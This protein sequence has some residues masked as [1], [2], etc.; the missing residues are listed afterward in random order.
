METQAQELLLVDTHSHLYLED[1]QEDADQ[2]VERSLRGEF[3]DL[4]GRRSTDIEYP[5]R[6]CG[7]IQPGI[8][9]ETSRAAL[10]FCQ[11]SPVLRC[12]VGIHPNYAGKAT[13]EEWSAITELAQNPLVVGIGETGLDLYWDYTPLDCQIDFLKRHVQLARRMSLPIII[14]CRSAEAELMN[15]LRQICSIHEPMSGII[16][17]FSGNV[18]MAEEC[19][20]YGFHISFSGSVTYP[21]KKFAS[22]WEA[23][24]IVPEDKILLETDS[25]FLTPHPFRGKLERNEPLMTA[26]VAKRLAELR[27]TTIANIIR[28]TTKNAIQIFHLDRSNG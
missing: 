11:K 15:I 12:A 1:F 20:Q 17:S 8:S 25:P 26:F 6:M 7:I 5:F 10:A 19:L 14:H 13:E 18:E 22:V 3:P 4:K 2:V 27:N 21:N 24:K 9:L 28:Q 16:H 23:A